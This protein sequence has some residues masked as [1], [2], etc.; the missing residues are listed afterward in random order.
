MERVLHTFCSTMKTVNDSRCTVS[1]RDAVITTDGFVKMPWNA[2]VTVLWPLLDQVYRACCIHEPAYWWLSY[3][4][5][6]SGTA[7]EFCVVVVVGPMRWL[8]IAYSMI[9]QLLVSMSMAIL[10]LKLG[11]C[12]KVRAPGNHR[13]ELSQLQ[14]RTCNQALNGYRFMYVCKV[15]VRDVILWD[16][17]PADDRLGSQVL[18]VSVTKKI[19]VRDIMR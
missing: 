15:T 18:P 14:K 9:P 8:W 16:Y 3:S 1:Y 2:S 7:F 11:A 19:L 5:W 4:W 13:I 6:K 17:R 10:R 12:P